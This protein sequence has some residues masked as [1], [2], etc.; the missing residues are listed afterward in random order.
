MQGKSLTTKDK[1]TIFIIKENLLMTNY[2]YNGM[3]A[4]D[5]ANNIIAKE[6]A[7]LTIDYDALSLEEKCDYAIHHTGI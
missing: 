2:N 3:N 5:I 1:N 6:E 7:Y 4:Q